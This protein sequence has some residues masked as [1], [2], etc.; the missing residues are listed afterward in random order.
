MGSYLHIYFGS[1]KS[2]HSWEGD[3]ETSAISRPCLMTCFLG[4]KNLPQFRLDW[5]YQKIILSLTLF[6]LLVKALYTG[7]M[8]GGDGS[9]GYMLW[10]RNRYTA[11]NF[12]RVSLQNEEHTSGFGHAGLYVWVL[13]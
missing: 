7:Q 2:D 6:T 5:D 4:M 3:L 9:L 11:G 13:G 10:L 12:S 8:A 1:I